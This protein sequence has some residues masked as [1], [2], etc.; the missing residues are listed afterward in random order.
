MTPGLG[1]ASACLAIAGL[2]LSACTGR[3]REIAAKPILRINKREVAAK[4]FADRLAARLKNFDALY[5][6]DEGNLKRAKEQTIQAFVLETVAR[7]YAESVNI[8][9]DS[10]EIEAEAQAIRSRYPDD[11]AFRRSLAQEGLAFDAWKKS[12]DLV[13]LQRKI[14]AKINESS[15][16]PSEA[17]MKAHYD[18]NQPLWNRPARIRLRQAVLGKEEDAQRV[19][20]QLNDGGK[21]A[22]LAREFSIAPE[23]DQDGDTGWIEKGTLEVFDQA[24]KLNV[25]ARSKVLKSPYGF[26]IYEVIAKEP[27]AHLSFADAKAK[28]RAQLKERREQSD[29]SAWL[30]K[31]IRQASVYRDDALIQAIKITTRGN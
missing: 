22:T 4:E 13:V 27:E 21:M 16:E 29:F 17:E 3:E 8:S 12:L 31:Q 20:A 10:G 5:A 25:G 7:D 15:P 2:V 26:H 23:A 19:L 28:I 1:G 18:Q 30:E 14:F 6:K 24:F 9:V 11:L